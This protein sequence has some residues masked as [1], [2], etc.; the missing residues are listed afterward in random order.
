MA[1]WQERIGKEESDTGRNT[2]DEQ[3]AHH[4]RWS[5]HL[6]IL[7]TQHQIL[8]SRANATAE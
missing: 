7:V 3:E 4:E 8:E 2:W 1:C 6:I 5:D